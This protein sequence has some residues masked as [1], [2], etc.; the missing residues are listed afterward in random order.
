MRAMALAVPPNA[1]PG[2]LTA[3]RSGSGLFQRVVLTWT[4]NSVNETNWTIQRATS[5][6]GPWTNVA[7]IQSTTS[8]TTGST[9]MYEDT[10]AARATLYYYQVFASN[11]VGAA[12]PNYPQVT[13]DSAPAVSNAVLTY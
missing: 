10:T 1:A 12:V 4:D 11:T 5:L 7:V 13:A 6:A 2:N 9:V 8:D 3:S